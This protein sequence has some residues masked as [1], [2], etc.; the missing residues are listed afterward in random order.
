MLV[1]PIMLIL[2]A[3]GPIL[4]ALEAAGHD[5]P[6]VDGILDTAG[7]DAGLMSGLMNGLMSGLKS[8]LMNGL[9]SG[10]MGAA[11]GC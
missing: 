11:S 5:V 6:D 1:L 4:S 2:G 8:G 3:M 7:K 10:L 9:M